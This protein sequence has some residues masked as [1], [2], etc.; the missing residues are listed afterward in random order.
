MI[1]TMVELRLL[2]REQLT[3]WEEISRGEGTL[4]PF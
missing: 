3:L 4:P 2:L 1:I